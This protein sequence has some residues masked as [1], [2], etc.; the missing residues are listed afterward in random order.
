M[1]DYPRR[2]RVVEAPARK[3][4]AVRLHA[5]RVVRDL[6]GDAD[7]SYLEQEGFEDR[8]KSYKRG[9]LHFV[10]LCVEADVIVDEGVQALVTSPG[11]GGIESDT[12]EEEF[13]AL[14]VEEWSA[15]RAALK[16]MG[17]ST[18]QLPREV[19]SAWIEWRT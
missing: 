8:Y 12:T 9:Q 7:V 3:Q 17:V 19:D 4:P 15:L 13:D 6:D 5:V 1:S 2:R 16:T 18:D 11:I 10:T 14:I